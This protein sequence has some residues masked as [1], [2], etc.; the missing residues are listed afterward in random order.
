MIFFNSEQYEIFY[1]RTG[2]SYKKN[3]VRIYSYKYVMK[4]DGSST[5]FFGCLLEIVL[6]NYLIA[7]KFTLINIFIFWAIKYRV[8]I[9]NPNM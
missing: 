9:E 8:R 2:S 6:K 7:T 1:I 4:K 5:L 3:F